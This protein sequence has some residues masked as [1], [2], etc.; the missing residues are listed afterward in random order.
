M[1]K[2][3]KFIKETYDLHNDKNLQ[4]YAEKNN[5]IN[6]S[7]PNSV[8]GNLMNKYANSIKS[9]LE[10]DDTRPI[11][12]IKNF[13]HNNIITKPENIPQ[14]YWNFYEK[15]INIPDWKLTK[16][17]KEKKTQEIINGQ[18]NR[19]NQWIDYLSNN[20]L[21][22]PIELK[23]RVIR[24]ISNLSP[25]DKSHYHFKRRTIKTT[26][27]FPELVK[28]ELNIV[29]QAQL[30]EI[31]GDEI[32]NPRPDPKFQKDFE[33][34]KQKKSFADR[35]AIALKV[36]DNILK[37]NKGE[38]RTYSG[39]DD[40]KKIEMAIQWH[41]T[42]RCL[43][44]E[45]MAKSHLMY[46]KTYVFFSEEDESEKAKK[47]R[48]AISKKGDKIKEI[49]GINPHQRIEPEIIPILEQKLKEFWD[50][51][52]EWKEY[53]SCIQ[54]MDSIEKSFEQNKEL[55]D[56]QLKFMYLKNYEKYFPIMQQ[57]DFKIDQIKAKR[58]K[59][60]DLMKLLNCKKDQ[61]SFSDE[62]ISIFSE[63]EIL[64]HEWNLN[65]EE[66]EELPKNFKF[67][68]YLTWDLNLSGLKELPQNI[69]L[70][71]VI[72]WSLYINKIKQIPPNT[73]FPK[74]I[75]GSLEI[76]NI[77]ELT[78]NTELPEYIWDNR[79]ITSVKKIDNNLEIPKYC[80]KRVMLKKNIDTSTE[81]KEKIRKNSRNTKEWA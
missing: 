54:Q 75:W 76:S 8:I 46:N 1:N 69:I 4:T 2:N 61:L 51:P 50:I 63:K 58:N 68:K 12:N 57:K 67:P 23:Y 24:S 25:L 39:I 36:K 42:G 9:K 78:K 17:Q 81:Q 66:R 13:L 32:K 47:P 48:L 74:R 44:D 3:I 22:Y 18:K 33:L 43:S 20:N 62:D 59:E 77:E 29:L 34:F 41:T 21:D 6:K 52:F 56:E 65:L 14:E 28:D 70:P 72:W 31:N 27:N 7:D 15:T 10:L 73:K 40:A 60:K 55:T 71:E 19:I 79:G 30:Q 80:W 64:Y 35:Y 49:S 38:R 5:K 11:A 26:S 45:D 37:N 16:E 53:I